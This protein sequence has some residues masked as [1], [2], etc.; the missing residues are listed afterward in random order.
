MC[1]VQSLYVL[2]YLYIHSYIL[3]YYLSYFFISLLICVWLIAPVGSFSL[4]LVGLSQPIHGAGN[5]LLWH[6]LAILILA[7][8]FIL[9][10]FSTVFSRELW[11][12]HSAMT[13][14]SPA[15]EEPEL[16]TSGCPLPHVYHLEIAYP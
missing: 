1:K 12:G 2:L 8:R 13:E 14:K 15:A 9:E 7:L 3:M 11:V 10:T 5:V 6:Y 16:R 4:G